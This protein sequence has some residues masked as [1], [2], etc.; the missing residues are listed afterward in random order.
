MFIQVIQG[1]V[2]DTTAVQARFDAW[3]EE[4]APAAEGWLGATAGT[5]DEGEFIAVVRF[6]SETAARHNSDR[7]EQGVWWAETSRLFEGGAQFHDYPDTDVLL[8]GGSD[9]AGFVQIMQGTYMG[10]GTPADIVDDEA[11]LA[12]LRPEIVGG[13]SGWNDRGHFTQAVYFTSEEAARRG[14]ETMAEDEGL[15]RQV[16]RWLAR[17]ENIRYLDLKHPWLA[18]P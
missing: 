2:S 16:E 11:V 10:E 7:P 12:S 14:E 1:K 13:I 3:V 17:V 9:D 5:T 6:E 15:A 8:G 18:S 4:L